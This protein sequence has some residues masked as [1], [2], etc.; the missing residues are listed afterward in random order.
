MNIFKKLIEKYKEWR[1][2]NIEKKTVVCPAK[3]LFDILDM[4]EKEGLTSDIIFD[5]KGR[6]YVFGVFGDFASLLDHPKWYSDTNT[7]GYIEYDTKEDLKKNARLSDRL[8]A[9]M[10]DPVIILE[11]NGC[12]PGPDIRMLA[13]RYAGK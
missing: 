8:I 7:E 1:A 4:Q 12:F 5:Y 9:E 11:I 3:M 13:D 6:I 10:N 2:R